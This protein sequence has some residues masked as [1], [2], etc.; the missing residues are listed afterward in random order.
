M[1]APMCMFA[2]LLG[3]C[4]TSRQRLVPP[5]NVRLTDAGAVHVG[6]RVERHASGSSAP[7]PSKPSYRAS[8]SAVVTRWMSWWR[9]R[10][11]IVRKGCRRGF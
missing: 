7:A 10:T 11:S 4:R 1:L 9:L 6:S 8:C 3:E 2:L 5:F